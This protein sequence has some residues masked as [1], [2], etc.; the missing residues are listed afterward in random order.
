[1]IDIDSCEIK[2]QSSC[3]INK[4]HLPKSEETF[5]KRELQSVTALRQ[6]TMCNRLYLSG[7]SIFDLTTSRHKLTDPDFHEMANS[8]NRWPKLYL[9]YR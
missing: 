8:Y 3:E 7:N 5:R 6:N 4:F 1:M 2:N 9:L